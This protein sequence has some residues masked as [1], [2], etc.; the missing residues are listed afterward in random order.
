MFIWPPAPTVIKPSKLATVTTVI[1]TALPPG[2]QTR[3]GELSG[4]SLYLEW[5]VL[6]V[7]TMVCG[8]DCVRMNAEHSSIEPSGD[9]TH[10]RHWRDAAA[11]TSTSQ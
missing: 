5:A 6:A 7:S 11:A 1:I 9:D 4:Q 8:A 10:P 2:R 3:L